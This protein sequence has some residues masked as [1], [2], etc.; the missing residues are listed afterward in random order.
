MAC[1]MT[2]TANAQFAKL[3][4]YPDIPAD[5]HATFVDCVKGYISG[6]VKS[7][8]GQYFG[9]VTKGG[10]IYGYGSF[11]T[12]QDGVVYG[13]FRNGNLLFG[14]KMGNRIVK[15]GTSDHYSVYD[16]TTGELLYIIKNEQ[17]YLPDAEAKSK[18]KFLSL[19]YQNGDKFVGE[20]IDG[21]RE[22]YGIYFYSNG[23]YYYGGYR[24][25]KPVGYGALFKT[26]NHITI[27]YWD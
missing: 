16:L 14:I 23:N 2:L 17:K 20:C 7:M 18:Y 4:R 22:G 15:V 5:Y 19:N 10:D 8:Y 26:N 24:D 12:D 11:Y 6:V 21:K 3:E 13:E 27:Q 9:Q 1:G 25:N